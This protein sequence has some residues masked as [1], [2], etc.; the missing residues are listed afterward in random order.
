MKDKFECQECGKMVGYNERHTYKD[1]KKYLKR[2][3]KP[4]NKEEKMKPK[5]IKMCKN[6]VVCN[7]DKFEHI[8]IGRQ[9][10]CGLRCYDCNEIVLCD[11]C[12]KQLK[13]KE[14]AR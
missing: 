14:N 2:F 4:S 11:D 9:T 13:E 5:K 12:K 7:H 10:T 1:C 3:K 6:K 8:R